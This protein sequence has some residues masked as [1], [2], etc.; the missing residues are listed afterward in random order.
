MIFELWDEDAAFLIDTYAEMN[1][2]LE[3]VAATYHDY[4]ESAIQGWRLLRSTP[5]GASAVPIAQ[6]MDLV[7]LATEDRLLRSHGD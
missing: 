7:H 5:S 1:D 4:G 3:V 6:G 2:A